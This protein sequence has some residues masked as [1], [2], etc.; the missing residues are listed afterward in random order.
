MKGLKVVA[1]VAVLVCASCQT[2]NRLSAKFCRKCGQPQVKQCPK[3]QMQLPDKA[4]YCYLCG[5]A[6]GAHVSGKGQIGSVIFSEDDPDLLPK[7]EA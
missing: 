7:F 1:G 2:E 5:Y 4:N 6:V 3:C